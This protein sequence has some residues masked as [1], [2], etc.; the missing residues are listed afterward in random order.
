MDWIS[1]TLAGV[2]G[3]LAGLVSFLIVRKPRERRTAYILTFVV[4]L[5]AFN[6]LSS[7]FVLPRLREWRAEREI[8]R[9]FSEIPVYQL[10]ARHDP[11]VAGE[12]RSSLTDMVRRGESPSRAR[13]QIGAHI[14]GVVNKYLPR[15]SD[16]AITTYMAVFMRELEQLQSRDPDLCY[17]AVFP[18]QGGPVDMALYLDQATREADL[19][20]LAEV[21]RSASEAP[22]PPATAEEA[23]PVL[24]GV[25]ARVREA[26]GEDAALLQ[27]LESPD[28]DRAKACALI[29]SLY[30][31]ILALETARSGPV[32]RYMVSP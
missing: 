20:A 6:L 4:A 21:I 15:A 30:G 18:N 16:A 11:A 7:R 24:A 17:R 10:L 9:V 25:M 19:S 31:A 29:R 26:H 2:A 23:G 28:A 32:L 13:E 8:D 5:G 3:A 22:Q 1:I 12:I 27:A 14:R